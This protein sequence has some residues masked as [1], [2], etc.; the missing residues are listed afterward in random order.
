MSCHEILRQMGYR[1]TPQRLMVLEILH[2]AEDHITA[3]EIF[4]RVKIRYPFVNRS[5]V[6]RTLDLLN[7]LGLV[8]QSESAGD[9]VCYHHAEKGHHHHLI[10]SKCGQELEASE[11]LSTALARILSER[12]EFTADLRHLTIHGLC[13]KCGGRTAR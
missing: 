11:E 1:L 8:T 5:T 4:E 6:Y 10:C 3:P 7:N 12:Y 2:E 13:S 9:T